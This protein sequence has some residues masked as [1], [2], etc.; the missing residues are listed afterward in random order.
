MT[1]ARTDAERQL[2]APGLPRYGIWTDMESSP[3][4]IPET[5]RIFPNLRITQAQVLITGGTGFFGQGFARAALAQGAGRVCIFSRSEYQQA[6]MRQE[7]SDD[8][9]RFFVGDVRDL[10]RLKRAMDGIDVVVH[11]AALKRVEVAE[12][13]AAEVV[14][15]NVIG[16]MNV[17][18]AA[19][20]AG[21]EKVV[22][23]ST[24]KACEPLNAYGATKL[25]AAKLFLAAN[26]ARGA[27]GPIFAV[28]R[29]GNVAGS[30]GSVIPTW[31]RALEQGRMVQVT[32][33]ECT[34]FWMTRDE[35]VGLVMDTI[36][37]MQGGELVIPDLPAYRLGDL[38]EAMG[39]S[40]ALTGLPAREK[41]HEAMKPGET[42]DMARRLTV[43]ELRRLLEHV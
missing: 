15:T 16:S 18:E 24:D 30:T 13:D 4:V 37:T 19:T 12:Y 21:V 43:D 14:K 5:S 11:A 17:I 3:M 29:Y 36:K 31:R 25:C 41:R 35:A 7:I 10:A 22:A 26:N 9:L 2:E 40:Y 8:R 1:T 6:L 32:D 34:R 42:S 27:T 20:D 28:C 33:P 38:A 23:L 39:V